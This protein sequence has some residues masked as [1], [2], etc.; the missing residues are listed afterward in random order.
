M[1]G[2]CRDKVVRTFRY[3]ILSYHLWPERFLPICNWGYAIECCLDCKR[4]GVCRVGVTKDEGHP[5]SLQAPSLEDMLE[6]WL[7]L[8]Y[9][10]DFAKVAV[11]VKAPR[12]VPRPG[13]RRSAGFGERR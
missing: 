1:T 9:D 12:Q 4:G 11:Q 13:E 5:I 6:R 3:L 8:P 10:Q 2:E 7:Q